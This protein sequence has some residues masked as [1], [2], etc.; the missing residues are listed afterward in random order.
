MSL[1]LISVCFLLCTAARSFPR[2]LL[3]LLTRLSV[4]RTPGVGGGV[5][6][7]RSSTWLTSGAPLGVRHRLHGNRRLLGGQLGGAGWLELAEAIKEGGGLE[8]PWKKLPV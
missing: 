4:P 8:E 3:P 6:R 2:A 1:V 5:V 7:F